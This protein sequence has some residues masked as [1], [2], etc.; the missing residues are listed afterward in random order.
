MKALC[1]AIRDQYTSDPINSPDYCRIVNDRHFKRVCDLL[2]SAPNKKIIIGGDRNA[3]AQ[4]IGPTVVT[5]I[6]AEDK[7]MQEEIF[8]PILPILTVQSHQEAIDFINLR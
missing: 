1:Q 3:D 4:Y 8:G 7:L 6:G 5:G 2:D